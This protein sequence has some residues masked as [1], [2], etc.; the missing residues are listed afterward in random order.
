MRLTLLAVCGR[1]IDM[2][3]SFVDNLGQLRTEDTRNIKEEYRWWDHERI[4]EDLEKTRT[5]YVSIFLNV[6]GDFNISSGIRAGLWFNTAGA[7]IVGKK[8][9]DRRGAVGAHNYMPVDHFADMEHLFAHL[10]NMDYQIIAAEI[11]DSATSLV[12]Y[13]WQEK[14]AVIFGEEN[15][16]VPQEVLD[17]CDEVVYI[18]GNGSIR[19]LNVSQT[20][21]IFAY[22]YF[23]KVVLQ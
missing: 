2:E 5:P 23:G 8:K 12:D 19:S 22:D 16:G 20:A 9:W 4:V 6:T 17:M 15:A 13:V 1:V 7:Y 10:R 11:S 14:T 21:G 3:T 18:P